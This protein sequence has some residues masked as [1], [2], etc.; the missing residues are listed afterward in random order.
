[1]S[2]IELLQRNVDH[3]AAMLTNVVMRRDPC[4]AN[5]KAMLAEEEIDGLV[6]KREALRQL[7]KA[8]PSSQFLENGFHYIIHDFP[9]NKKDE[10]LQDME[11]IDGELQDETILFSPMSRRSRLPSDGSEDVFEPPLTEMMINMEEDQNEEARRI[12]ANLKW[13]LRRQKIENE[14]WR[15]RHLSINRSRAA[16][17][18]ARLRHSVSFGDDLEIQLE[19][20]GMRELEKEAE[21]NVSKAEGGGATASGHTHH[22]RTS[23]ATMAAR[24]RSNVTMTL[25][26]NPNKPYV[27]SM[28]MPSKDFPDELPAVPH[29]RTGAGVPPSLETHEEEELVEEGEDEVDGEVCDEEEMLGLPPKDIPNMSMEQ[30]DWTETDDNEEEN[31]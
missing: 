3:P 7:K 18:V 25:G 28:S 13:N 26:R 21:E 5:S 27:R 17:G 22:H 2:S 23:T 15:L 16:G 6:S 19:Q 24:K 20:S 14:F 29:P 11:T 30:L 12:H 4:R 10:L 8:R 1:M 31:D 9:W